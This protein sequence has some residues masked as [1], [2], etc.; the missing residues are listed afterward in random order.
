ARVGTGPTTHDVLGGLQMS[1][2]SP[3]TFD[4]NE[5]PSYGIMSPLEGNIWQLGGIPSPCQAHAPA[6]L[7]NHLP[8]GLVSH[9]WQAR[10]LQTCR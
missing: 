6:Q 5:D 8:K 2:I 9:S 7:S 3:E 10:Q 4:V 1:A